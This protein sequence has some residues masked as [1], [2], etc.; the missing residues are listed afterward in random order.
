MTQ[1]SEGVYRAGVL[2]TGARC[3]RP[4]CCVAE[5]DDL[6]L[7]GETPWPS[8]GSC[9]LGWRAPLADLEWQLTQ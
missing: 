4:S 1:C 8:S 5:S 7:L 9:G 2:V 3:V 6:V